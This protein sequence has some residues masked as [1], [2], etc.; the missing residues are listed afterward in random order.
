MTSR[1][2]L[3]WRWY[4]TRSG[5]EPPH[6]AVRELSSDVKRELGK[7]MKLVSVFGKRAARHLRNDI[8]EVRAQWQGRAYRLLFAVEG[9][10]ALA[11]LF[12]EKKSQKTP[13]RYIDTAER[14]LVDHRCT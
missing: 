8:W 9:D 3:R 7:Q 5:R 10:M 2:K 11:L 14:R 12:F 13:K 6:E 4:A 1:E